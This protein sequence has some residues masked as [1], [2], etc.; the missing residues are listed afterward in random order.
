MEKIVLTS[1]GS[2]KVECIK[3]V[4][5]LTGLG[6]KETK[7]VID[8]I[9]KGTHF[10]IEVAIGSENDVVTQFVSMGANAY[11]ENTSTEIDEKERENIINSEVNMKC[12]CGCEFNSKF[13]PNC[14][15]RAEDLVED[16]NTPYSNI[17][18]H[19]YNDKKFSNYGQNNG[20]K[21]VKEM[22]NDED[23]ANVKETDKKEIPEN[24]KGC[25]NILGIGV[26]ILAIMIFADGMILAGVL[27][28]VG[29]VIILTSKSKLCKRIK[30]III[31]TIFIILGLIEVGTVEEEKSIKKQDLTESVSEFKE[32]WY[33]DHCYY[34]DSNGN[35]FTLR[36]SDTMLQLNIYNVG[37]YNV[38][39]SGYKI[40]KDSEYGNVYIYY[41]MESYEL[42]KYY[43]QLNHTIIVEAIS[44]D[45][46]CTNIS[47]AEYLE[48]ERNYAE[49]QLEGFEE[50]WYKGKYIGN[51]NSITYKEITDSADVF[52]LRVD[53]NFDY[54]REKVVVGFVSDEYEIDYDNYCYVYKTTNSDGII[55]YLEYYPKDNKIRVYDEYGSIGG[56]AVKTKYYYLKTE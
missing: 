48:A 54:I 21:Q 37:S 51:N 38:G 45:I 35:Y 50:D 55:I 11:V 5:E 26:I 49:S 8:D 28:S 13:C 56:A 2:N 19:L 29:G 52:T 32:D 47:E 9:E 42:V 23:I 1:C 22:Q 10:S 6:L 18:N 20:H 46:T 4:R 27:F 3:L 43:P 33:I 14:G 30:S 34:V 7:D 15:K 12:I 44:G 17:Q 53:P 31:A 24:R 40:E 25:F 41:D 39:I 16:N 36:Y